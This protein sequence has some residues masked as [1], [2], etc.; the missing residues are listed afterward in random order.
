MESGIK[1]TEITES[2]PR[3]LAESG[4][5]GKWEKQGRREGEGIRE[6]PFY[7]LFPPGGEILGKKFF[8]EAFAMHNLK[9]GGE[10]V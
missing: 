4:M 6:K 1:S 5:W 7:L 8:L 10:T 2:L 9:R 3:V